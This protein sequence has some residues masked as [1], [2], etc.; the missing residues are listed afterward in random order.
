MV[1]KLYDVPILNSVPLT[2]NSAYL[3]G[4][5]DADGSIYYNKASRQIFIS[6]SQKK[7]FILDLI[8]SVY[9]GIVKPSNKEQSAFK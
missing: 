6:L 7:R 4:L 8:A 5:F 3:S 9:G 1:C 2:Y